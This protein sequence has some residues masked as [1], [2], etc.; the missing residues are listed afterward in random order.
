MN[1]SLQNNTCDME[2]LE[3][4]LSGDLS[5][6]EERDFTLHLNTCENCRRS[7]QQQAA[8]PEAWTEAERLLKP[9]EFD[10]GT[11]E[12]DCDWAFRSRS[13]RQPLQIQN[14]LTALGPT[15]DPAMLGRLGGYEVSGVVGAGGMGVV[16]KAIDKSLDRTVAIKVLAPHLATSGAARKRF[17]REA[18]AAA[19]V[20][21]PNVIAIHSVSNDESLPYLVMP[22]VRG[23]S[24]QKRLD[25]EGPLSLQEIL[26]IG[27]QIAAGLAAAH[28][29]GLVHRDI[30][31]A[32]ILLEDGVERVTITDFGLARAV[33]DA[34]ITHSGVIAG[35]PQYMSPE[36]AR[37]EAVDGRSDLF[38][39]GSVLY[40]I[41]TGRPPFRAESS[42]GVLRRITDD[43]PT[44]IREINP[45]V[46]E[47]L[48]LIIAKLMSKQ[49]ASRF[50]SAEEVSELFEKCLAH[51]Q[52]PAGVALPAFLIPPTKARHSLPSRRS[53]GV[54]A[55]IIALLLSVL[56]I[57]GWNASEAPDI[58]GKWSGEGWGEVKLDK[59]D[60]G[61]YDG[62]YTDTFSK[63]AGEIRLKW[64]RIEQR[65]NGTWKEGKDRF[66]KVSV[67]LVG[68]EI[69]GA[70][71]TSK[72]SKIDP[73]RPRLADLQWVRSTT[74]PNAE[75][76]PGIHVRLLLSVSSH[77]RRVMLE[78]KG[79]GDLSILGTGIVGTIDGKQSKNLS[80]VMAHGCRLESI[81]ETEYRGKKYWDAKV[82]VPQGPTSDGSN[83]S[84]SQKML[85]GMKELGV[86]F[87]LDHYRGQ[88]SQTPKSLVD[89][90]ELRSSTGSDDPKS[91]ISKV[92]E[93]ERSPKS[94]QEKAV[95]KLV[96]VF[97]QDKSRRAVPCL[98]LNMGEN[99]IV[100]TAGTAGIVPDGTEHA[101][102][103]TFLEIPGKPPLQVV[104]D[105]RSTAELFFYSVPKN[106][107]SVQLKE[108][109][110]LAAKDSVIA[111]G[112]G[113]SYSQEATI[114]ALD[115]QA[116]LDLSERGLI[117]HQYR[118]LLEID[119]V[120]P[121]GTPLYK[122][123][124][125]VGLTL[126]GSRFLGERGVK[127]YVVPAKRIVELCERIGRGTAEPSTNA[128]DRDWIERMQG[129]I[130]D[131]PVYGDKQGDLQL[132][133]AVKADQRKV[134]PGDELK[135]EY[136]IQNAG[137]KQVVFEYQPLHC[138]GH[139]PDIRNQRGEKE[140]VVG[141]FPTF[142]RPTYSVILEP[143]N[144]HRI[145]HSVMLGKSKEGNLTPSWESPAIGSYTLR[146]GFSVEVRPAEEP[147][148]KVTTSLSSGSVAFEVVKAV[149]ADV[150][151]KEAFFAP[152]PRGDVFVVEI[153]AGGGA[154]H[155]DVGKLVLALNAI[156]GVIVNILDSGA[157]DTINAAIVRD[158][159]KVGAK[160]A[161]ETKKEDMIRAAI[162]K[163]LQAAN[164]SSVRWVQGNGKLQNG[165]SANPMA[166]DAEAEYQR[167]EGVWRL[168]SHVVGD[169][170]TLDEFGKN[171]IHDIRNRQMGDVR[172]S[173]D[174]AKTPCEIDLTFTN[175]PDKGKVL[176]GIYE[177][178][179]DARGTKLLAISVS[180][181]LSGASDDASHRPRDFGVREAV[182][183]ALLERIKVGA[184]P[185]ST[186]PKEPAKTDG[187]DATEL[188]MFQGT[189]TLVSS[190]KDG[191]EKSEAKN[192]YALT[193]TGT[194]WKV[195]HGDEVA[196]EGT[197]RL[198]DV[199]STP[200]KLDLLKPKGLGPD[201]TVDYGIYE[202]KDNTLRYC[203]RNGP[204]GSEIP[205][206]LDISKLRPN[207]FSTKNGDGRI[208]Y[209]WK[210][211]EP[212]A[213]GKEAAVRSAN[214]AGVAIVEAAII[215]EGTAESGPL[216]F[217]ADYPNQRE[218]TEG[219]LKA[220]TAPQFEAAAKARKLRFEKM[221]KDGDPKYYIPTGDGHSVIV[222]FRDGKW[223]GIQRIRGEQHLNPTRIVLPDQPSKP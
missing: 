199:A 72:E 135:Y 161:D 195:H 207:E 80:A 37:G 95:A 120:F 160:D 217:L 130:D 76:V 200:R 112:I 157:G 45:D 49:A 6:V 4:F 209:V 77:S 42:Y 1:T 2:R 30:K 44:S 75:E 90:N 132:G 96:L 202:W 86:E 28:A 66:G 57:V 175:G 193:F 67:R 22:Y 167:L 114:V 9:S 14:V 20:L 215:S 50:A 139:T 165:P 222:M 121:E 29:Q 39:L 27:S 82:F 65:F 144:V 10:L 58:A 117:K 192:P 203:V 221:T 131:S 216:E 19:A 68:D 73:G 26:R 93:T 182:D 164:V 211:A 84:L 223:S 155:Q 204:V 147:K 128:T 109:A 208:L 125:L 179:S 196:V 61:S 16:L 70:W 187:S 172:I 15:D 55:M 5:H 46:P 99:T 180:P 133:L 127:S 142:D 92:A 85:D 136:V 3:S 100:V 145:P 74:K 78:N 103:R 102:D 36:Q 177:W 56:A 21:H 41:C 79:F 110:E 31:P 43:E 206:G 83:R 174:P 8:E 13:T 63:K 198:V 113:A 51:V 159:V 191:E 98:V 87:Q 34:T 183:F 186:S 32:N 178:I 48:C 24:L 153:Y 173:L 163:A 69:R 158:P 105:S 162:G 197:L 33:D 88:A 59:S 218:Q 194:H 166:V 97:S 151:P 184:V 104:Y 138:E 71:T 54:I 170:V 116:E 210:R 101:I 205:G 148:K 126:L 123:G 185:N 11:A 146:G 106:L 81:E 129:K 52:Q 212:S 152:I 107:G 111:M 62:T 181:K 190:E 188:K 124:K 156:Q 213:A 220:L 122:E 141:V 17:A 189:W 60:D 176:R 115:R 94:E 53:L 143:G 119:R 219:E 108:I 134:R 154:K 12:E 150:P 91:Q 23:T 89:A 18:K 118:G 7:L 25:K 140:S 168:V 137:K 40:A 169:V 47:W 38:S 214:A 64:S 35:T 149:A 171:G 201:P